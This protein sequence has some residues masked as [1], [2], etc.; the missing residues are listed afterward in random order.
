MKRYNGDDSW[1]VKAKKLAKKKNLKSVGRYLKRLK[2][3]NLHRG[4]RSL[5]A[6]VTGSAVSSHARP[7]A[8]AANTPYRSNGIIYICTAAAAAAS[9]TRGRA[10]VVAFR[11]ARTSRAQRYR[12]FFACKAIIYWRDGAE[13]AGRIFRTMLQVSAGVCMRVH[14][15]VVDTGTCSVQI[16]CQRL[17]AA[18]IEY[19]AMCRAVVRAAC[20][21][22]RWRW[23]WRDD[24]CDCNA[25]A[26]I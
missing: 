13:C 26:T 8:F 14:K 16:V 20:G 2:P 18:A 9:A 24:C 22:G 12:P 5:A 23:C 15:S 17:D 7:D 3:L 10:A 11:Y 6:N 25:V 21:S 1:R 19:S 4:P